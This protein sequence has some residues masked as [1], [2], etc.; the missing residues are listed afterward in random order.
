MKSRR[1]FS[2]AEKRTIVAEIATIGRSE[3]MRKHKLRDSVLRRWKKRYGAQPAAAQQQWTNGWVATPIKLPVELAKSVAAVAI[4]AGEEVP[5]VI[6]VILALELLK[7][8][9][10]RKP[11]EL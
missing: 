10:G 9:Q 8:T 11:K 7:V 2:E 4:A 1:F 5:T 3:V 6:R